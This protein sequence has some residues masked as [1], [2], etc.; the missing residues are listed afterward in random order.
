[1]QS[2]DAIQ[3]ASATTAN[4]LRLDHR[5]GD[6]SEGKDADL[7]VLDQELSVKM[8]IVYNALK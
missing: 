7:V 8:K 4:S 3:M 1:V 6:I 2:K 5:K